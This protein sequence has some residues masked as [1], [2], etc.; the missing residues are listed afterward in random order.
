MLFRMWLTAF[1]AAAGLLAGTANAANLSFTGTFSKDDD[2]QLFNFTVTTTSLVT[3]VSLSYAGGVNS[4]GT[5]IAEGGFDPILTLFDATG[6]FIERNDDG[7]DG[8]TAGACPVPA[9]SVTLAE[10]D[11]CFQQTLDPGNYIV[12]VQQFDNFALGNL[13]DG[14]AYTGQPNFTA[15]YGCTNGQFCDVAQLITDDERRP[16]RRHELQPQQCL[17]VRHPERRFGH[18]SAP[19]GD[20][21]VPGD[22]DCWPRAARPPQ[23][24]WCVLVQRLRQDEPVAHPAPTIRYGTRCL[25]KSEKSGNKQHDDDQPND[26]DDVVHGDSCKQGTGLPIAMLTPGAMRSRYASTPTR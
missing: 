11:T 1:V 19:A 13:S 23:L 5:T 3:L 18:G 15:Q 10:F 9:S 6:T 26:V 16:D 14:F 4:A 24:A 8:E 22:G 20:V 25:A 17:G 21:L 7:S 2:V 12:A